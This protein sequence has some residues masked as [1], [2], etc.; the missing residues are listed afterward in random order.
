PALRMIHS[1]VAQDCLQRVD[2]SFQ[3]FFGD[4]KAKIGYPRFKKLDKYKSFTFPQV[5]KTVKDKKTGI[6]RR[7]KIVKFKPVAPS[8]P[9]DKIKFAYL[10]LPGI[11]NLKIR[12]HRPIDWDNAKTVAVKRSPSG[13]WSVSITVELPMAPSL[14]D[15][16]KRSGIDLGLKKH[17]AL[18]DD[19]YVEYP[20]FLRQSE[21]KLKREQRS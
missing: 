10:T 19:S 21:R 5:W 1:Q 17:L 4:V 7:F 3:K 2:K 13:K 18:S 20:K 16:G 12:L 9:G 6:T 8:K 15:N 11:G 14:A